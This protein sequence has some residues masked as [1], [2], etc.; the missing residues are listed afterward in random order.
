[1]SGKG[2]VCS[3]VASILFYVEAAAKLQREKSCTEELSRW[4][5]PKPVKDTPY[6]PLSKINF[7]NSTTQRN[8][9]EEIQPPKV[10][11]MKPTEE[12]KAQFLHRLSLSES[13]PAIL[14]LNPKYSS[15]Y[16]PISVKA[17]NLLIGD[18]YKPSY[19]GLDEKNLD[20]K[21]DKVKLETTTEILKELELATLKQSK[22]NLWFEVR[23]GR[24]TASKLK[25]VCSTNPI[26]PSM[27]LLKQICY[28]IQNK[29]T[30]PATEWGLKNESKALKLYEEYMKSIHINFKL[31]KSGI[32][33][34][35]KWLFMGASPDG[36]VACDCCGS[37]V[38]E[39]K[40]P[41]TL[42]SATIEEKCSDS[43]FCLNGHGEHKSLKK[44]HQYYYQVQAQ[45]NITESKYCDFLVYSPNEVFLE[46]ILPDDI[47]WKATVAKAE[48]FFKRC[49]LPEILGRRFTKK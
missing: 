19:L 42:K 28:P 44:S 20:A 35:K 34:N 47:F 30:T 22:C 27:S 39:V 38:V 21:C 40:C 11:N 8:E 9:S 14:A 2:E 10:A 43:T 16:E 41:Y 46:R 15:K 48:D 49:V 32:C 17:R 7:S 24:I 25:N 1:M 26:T 6:L 18:L 31:S 5:L 4:V 3:H 45:I 13:R 37:G 12:Q 29:F 36:K 23:T 33:L